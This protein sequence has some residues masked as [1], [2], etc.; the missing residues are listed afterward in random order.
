MEVRT[1]D[2]DL[3]AYLE[4]NRDIYKLEDIANIHAEV[5]GHNDDDYWYWIIELKDGRFVYTWAWCDY[6]GW[7][8]QSGGESKVADSIEA[9]ALLAPENEPGTYRNPRRNLLAQVRG[10]QAFGLEFVLNQ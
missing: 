8:C 1:P 10:E 2:Y 4:S 7:D 9:A 3:E 5:P 6:T